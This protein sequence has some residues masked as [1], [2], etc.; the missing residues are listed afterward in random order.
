MI[1][2]EHQVVIIDEVQ[3]VPELLDEVHRLIEDKAIRFILTGSSARKIK[4]HGGN[5][6]A[7]RAWKSELY[8]L[9]YSERK[10][11]RQKSWLNLLHF[12]CL[13]RVY[14]SEN[15]AEE[16]DAYV[17]TYL[18]EE[19]ENEH[20]VKSLSHFSRFLKASALCAGELLCFQ[21]LSSDVGVSAV[22]IKEY[23]SILSDTLL[24]SFLEPYTESKKRKA[25]GT[26]KFYYFDTGV[27]S[28][29]NEI[30]HLERNS[31]LYGK[32]LEHLLCH[33][34]KAY[35]SYKRIKKVLRFW[36]TTNQ[37]EVDFLIGDDVAIE[38][39]ASTKINPRFLKGLKALQ[40]EQ[41]FKKFF[42]VTH[43]PIERMEDG[44]HCLPVDEF[45][46]RLWAGRI[47]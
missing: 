42:L 26:A 6:L 14:L 37:N 40:E 30:E 15:P 34:L 43:D 19:I 12:G 27:L 13:P 17:N 24:G 16:I 22:T 1:M 8:P 9:V 36:R 25:I 10:Q 28:S 33:E 3:K 2:P 46:A 35:L 29:L 20:W 32:C 5:M 44:V 21:N 18:R 45:L 41:I 4:R 7:G 39:K 31:S 38:V 11:V 23:Y 47:I